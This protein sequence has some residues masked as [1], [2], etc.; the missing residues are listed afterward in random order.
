MNRMELLTNY[1][2]DFWDKKVNRVVVISKIQGYPEQDEE[3]WNNQPAG[4][5]SLILGIV[6]S[7]KWRIK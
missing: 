4:V 7:K 1:N 3:F 6:D 5:I 2:T